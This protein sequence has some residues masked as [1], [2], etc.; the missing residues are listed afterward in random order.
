MATLIIGRIST[1]VLTRPGRDADSLRPSADIAARRRKKRRYCQSRIACLPDEQGSTLVALH[2]APAANPFAD[3][4]ARGITRRR[5]RVV[6]V[7]MAL[8]ERSGSGSKT[9]VEACRTEARGHSGMDHDHV[10]PAGLDLVS[11][12][13]QSSARSPPPLRCPL[14]W[15]DVV[16][17]AMMHEHGRP[18]KAHRRHR[19]L[20]WGSSL[21]ARAS[22]WNLSLSE[23]T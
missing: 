16:S 23:S 19:G 11:P 1:V 8:S 22:F 13:R 9:A 4:G 2:A 7:V 14:G 5:L 6:Q 21:A 20:P 18:H 3:D 10:L 12:A 17:L 15:A